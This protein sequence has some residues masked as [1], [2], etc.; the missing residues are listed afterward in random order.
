MHSYPCPFTYKKIHLKKIT[1]LPSLKLKN[2][3]MAVSISSLMSFFIDYRK[4]MARGKNHYKSGHVEQC[5]L[6]AGLLT[7]GVRVSMRDKV[8][9]VSVREQRERGR[10]YN[11]VIS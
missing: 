7:S 8:Y 4:S 5:S 10:S 6:D 3:A 9:R 1:A 11:G 2:L